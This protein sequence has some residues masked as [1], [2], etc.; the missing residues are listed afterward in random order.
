MK[1]NLVSEFDLNLLPTDLDSNSKPVYCVNGIAIPNDL[2][3]KLN[4]YFNRRFME[5]EED[6]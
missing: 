4:S 1:C 5:D 3:N 6:D 2:A